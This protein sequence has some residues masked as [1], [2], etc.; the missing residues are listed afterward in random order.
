MLRHALNL[1]RLCIEL[2]SS[3]QVQPRN[4]F[5]RR[6]SMTLRRGVQRTH[7]SYSACLAFRSSPPKTFLSKDPPSAPLPFSSL[8]EDRLLMAFDLEPNDR[9]AIEGIAAHSDEN[10][11]VR[12]TSN[13][14]S[15]TSWL[16]QR[17]SIWMCRAYP[18]GLRFSG[19]N[20]HP[21]PC[22]L[23]GVHCVALNM[24]N[25]D[26]PLQLHFALFKGCGG[27][28]LKP[29]EMVQ[30]DAAWPQPRATHLKTT[31]H[32]I[33]LHHLPKRRE[34]R[35]RYDGSSELCHMLVPELSGTSK[36]PDDLEPSSPA[37]DISLH[38]I[39]GA[40]SWVVITT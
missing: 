2:V 8:G 1:Y 3:V 11:L 12:L 36:L 13:P 21:I 29:P 9:D 31:I 34:R 25:N 27:Y 7:P 24:S 33:S 35:P 22:W 28:L 39:G 23:A 4:E 10:A 17:T 15:S 20:M 14:P 18:L 26:L 6:S 30:P 37:L 16:Q 19:K 5:R 40:P 38:A 32:V